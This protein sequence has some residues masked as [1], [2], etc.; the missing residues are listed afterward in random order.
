MPFCPKCRSEYVE[1]ITECADCKA[2]LVATLPPEAA[3]VD[4]HWAPLPPLTN[5]TEGQLLVE[6]L[7]G[8]GIR[9]MLKKDVFVSAFGSQGTT[10]F[11]PQER[12]AEAERLREETVG[13]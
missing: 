3:P 11:V 1:G 5:E 4:I 6:V 8:A 12:F 13:R 9:T 7:E 2:A 10:V